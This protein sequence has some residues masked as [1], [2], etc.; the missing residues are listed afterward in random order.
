VKTASDIALIFI[1]EA[2]SWYRQ[3]SIFIM[4]IL[5][6]VRFDGTFIGRGILLPLRAFWAAVGDAGALHC[7]NGR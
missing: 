2:L 7:G 6:P 1:P 4:A 5:L 3:N